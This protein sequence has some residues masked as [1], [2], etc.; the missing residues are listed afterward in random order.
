MTNKIKILLV[1]DDQQYYLD[2]LISM[3][4]DLEVFCAK[5]NSEALDKI[6][7][8]AKLH[9]SLN[10]IITDIFRDDDY[11]YGT[12][13][14][15]RIRNLPDDITVSGGLRVK[16]LPIIV[17]SGWADK[18]KNEI[19]ELDPNIPIIEKPA[20]LEE[21]Y[22]I[23]V[24]SINDY[25]HK[26]LSDL[27]H[28]GLALVWQ[29]GYF[30]AINAYSLPEEKQIDT[31]YI[32]GRASEVTKSYSKLVF[33]SESSK[34]GEILIEQF[35]KVLNYPKTTEKDIQEFLNLHPGFILQDKYDSY[36]SQPVLRSIQSSREIRPDYVLQP[37]GLRENPWN[38]AVVDLKKS[39]VPLF[40][41]KRFHPDLSH[42]V[43][44]VATQLKDYSD[45][46]SDP[47]NENAIRQKFGGIKPSPKLVAIIGRLPIEH[48]DRYSKLKDRIAGVY[49][50]TYD[51]IIEF[52][53]A[54]V[55]WKKSLGI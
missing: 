25:R 24:Q 4:A 16:H 20:H 41:N 14:I 8:I 40:T 28:I 45:F 3:G 26:V 2:A 33:V 39:T 30:R 43:Y 15:K 18:Y 34:I 9:I 27:E 29:D 35:E 12:H 37:R 7:A 55:S 54:K 49:I 31:K 32:S 51:E 53:K 46:F 17:I 21:L 50:R 23:I 22:K 52:H 48:I 1:D 42:H 10:M 19:L 36:W 5:N 38:W 13:L 6:D 44:R 47:R 11:G